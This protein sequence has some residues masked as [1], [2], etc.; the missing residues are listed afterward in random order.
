MYDKLYI[1]NTNDAHCFLGYHSLPAYVGA[2]KSFSKLII[3]GTYNCNHYCN[4]I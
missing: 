4:I 3:A 2:N 1:Y